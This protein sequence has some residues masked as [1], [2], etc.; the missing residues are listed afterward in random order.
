MKMLQK[1]V[2]VVL[3]LCLAFCINVIPAFAMENNITTDTN[4]LVAKT[5]ILNNID[6]YGSNW[7]K[8]SLQQIMLVLLKIR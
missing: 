1:M 5:A 6:E 3:G 2:A 7:G 4:T 8:R